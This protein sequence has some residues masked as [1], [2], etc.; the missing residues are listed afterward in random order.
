MIT[1]LVAYEKLDPTTR[2]QLA[3]ILKHHPRF[4]D[5]FHPLPSGSPEDQER[6]LFC[7][8]STWPDHV[9]PTNNVDG[10]IPAD[11]QIVTSFH[12][13]QWHFINFPIGLLPPGAAEAEISA[14]EASGA[15]NI[16]LSTNV[17]TQETLKMNVLQAIEFNAAILK[18]SH[19]KPAGRAVALCW[20]LHT[21]G[22][23]HQPLHSSALFTKTLFAPATHPEGDRGGNRITFISDP[24]NNLHS[25]W[26]DAP[27]LTDTFHFVTNRTSSLLADTNLKSKGAAAALITDP[28]AW[29]QESLGFARSLSYTDAIRTQILTAEKDNAIISH[30]IVNLPAGY[31][32]DAAMLS[33][34]RVVEGGFR[35]A[36]KLAG[37]CP[38]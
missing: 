26:D 18:D 33:R 2:T 6:W 19:N 3:E 11:P 38:H 9:R 23:I 25:V 22:D 27:G 21:V 24:H 4:A 29:A 37:C 14:L 1:A 17:P 31:T 36:A 32:D 16:N 5:D 28:V 20:L 30:G 35:L 13:E 15:T 7:Q 34:Q 8:A 10:T 12:R